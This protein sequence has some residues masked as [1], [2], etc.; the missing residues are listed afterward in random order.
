M[1][2]KCKVRHVPPI[3]RKCKRMEK[4][5]SQFELLQDAAVSSDDAVAEGASSY[6]QSIQMKILSQLEKVYRY[7][8]QVKDHTN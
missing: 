2:K 1:C 8:D 5:E 6:R 3:G 4:K 7:L